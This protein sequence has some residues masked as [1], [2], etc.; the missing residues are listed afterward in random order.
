M[1]PTRVN[2]GYDY[3]EPYDLVID[4]QPDV[5]KINNNTNNIKLFPNP[6][7]DELNIVL[8]NS[9]YNKVQI[10][11]ITGKV[12]IEKNIDNS[13]RVNISTSKLKDGIYFCK[14]YGEQ[15]IT[16]KFIISN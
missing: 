4:V 2:D 3:S 6:V 11:D 9:S 15:I 10:L 14:I 13:N 16:E 1:F 5:S 12:V 8:N 7:K